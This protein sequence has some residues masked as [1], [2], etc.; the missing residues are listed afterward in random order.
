M[1]IASRTCTLIILIALTGGFPALG[2]GTE[3]QDVVRD[4]PTLLQ[5]VQQGGRVQLGA[6][7]FRLTETLVI[8]TDIELVG[9]GMDRTVITS[10]ADEVAVWFQHDGSFTI[11]GITFEHTGV[12]VADVIWVYDGL[13]SI[14]DSR[15]TGG[16][17]TG[18]LGTDPRGSG[19]VLGGNTRGVVLDS[20]FDHNSHGVALL[21]RAQPTLQNNIVRNNTHSGIVYLR[22]SGGVAEGNTSE[23]NGLSGIQVTGQAQPTLR[24]NTVGLVKRFV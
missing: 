24:V 8:T 18:S 21:G 23:N 22:S 11:E 7:E 15:F 20:S 13:V 10:D 12:S 17:G 14:R 9:A 2:Q 3:Q 1:R 16:V 4:V 19:L 5:R 6:G